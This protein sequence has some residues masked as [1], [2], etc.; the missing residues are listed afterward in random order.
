MSNI[1]IIEDDKDLCR[2]LELQLQLEKYQT[3]TA[4]NATDGLRH[5]ETLQPDIVLLDLNLP[6][7]SGLKIL[8]ALLAAGPSVV[9]MT[10][11]PSNKMV[12]EAMR[13]GAFD[14]LRKPLDLHNVFNVLKKVQRHRRALAKDTNGDERSEA[15]KSHCHGRPRNCSKQR[16][17]APKA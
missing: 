10:G 17:K 8:P 6:D 3:D 14:Y 9:I 4:F 2:V 7:E 5:A 13:L 16:T 11:N 1:L 15:D 12:I